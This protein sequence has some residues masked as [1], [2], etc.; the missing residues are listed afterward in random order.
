M[1]RRHLAKSVDQALSA[2]AA[3]ALLGP[4][5]V[6][7]TTL[8]L[9]IGRAR[10]ALYLD[11]ETPEDRDKLAGGLE[12]LRANSG[13][14][15]ILDEIQR[16]PELFLGLRGLIDE[17]RRQGLRTGRFLLLGSAS[18]ELLRQ[19]GES[20]AG[21]I[22]Y[23][24]LTGLTVRETPD[25]PQEKLWLR[26]GYP[27][28]LTA[29]SDALSLDWRRDLIR[30]YLERDVPMLGSRVPAETLRR[31]WTMLAHGHGGLFNRDFPLGGIRRRKLW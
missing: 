2:Q 16:V 8:A 19:S 3:V 6:G 10:N 28:S 5:Q 1:F 21:R 11:L 23:L 22:R 14:L 4:R 13:R 24:E 15:I 26:G 12:Y 20:L 29:A 7:K 9:E 17:G 18:L 30:T 27:D 31:F 25:E